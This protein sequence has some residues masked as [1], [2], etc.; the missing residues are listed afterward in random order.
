MR[1]LYFLLPNLSVT[2]KVFDELLLQRV[3]DRHIHIISDDDVSLGDL[4]RA[5]LLQRSDFIPAMERGVALGG[6]AGI[7][8]GLVSLAF[9][10]IVIPGGA[11]LGLGLVGAVVGA[12][13]GGMIGMDVPNTRTRQFQSELTQGHILVLVD[14]P[15]G[16]VEEVQESI[17]KHHSDVSFAG[18]EPTIPAFP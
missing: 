13:V 14:V 5:S 17:R 12:W 6:G 9:P 7:V 15:K 16:R 8:A 18:T 2:R 10:G 4:P 3:D 11:L 1:R